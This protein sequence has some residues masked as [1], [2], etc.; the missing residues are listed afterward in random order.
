M[1]E[2]TKEESAQLKNA[3]TI[4]A[5]LKRKAGVEV[6]TGGEGPT[7]VT[8]LQKDAKEFDELARGGGLTELYS[9]DRAKFDRLQEA[10]RS[11]G[12]VDL[13][14]KNKAFQVP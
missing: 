1:A 12:E 11:L 2:L 5:E 4:V 14:Y 10:K 3:E 8:Q 13:V 9:T 7:D 6:G